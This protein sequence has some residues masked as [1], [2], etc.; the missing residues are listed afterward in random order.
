MKNWKIGIRVTAGFGA[1]VAIAMA[2]GIFAYSKVNGIENNAAEVVDGALPKVYLVG[3]IEKNV[4]RTLALA[5]QHSAADHQ[6][7]AGLEAQIQTIRSTNSGMVSQYEKLVNT[8][9]GRA[10]LQDFQA[11]RTAFWG[12]LDE[13]IQTSRTG[14]A[15]AKRR[16]SD[17]ISQRVEPLQEKYA[18]AAEAVVTLNKEAADEAGANPSW[19]PEAAPKRASRSVWRSL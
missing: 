15:D 7:M 10:L 4:H 19:I 3:Q 14:T 13:T 12:A 16:A 9:K 2:L 17:M 6:K 11:A 18:Q 5:L 1:V 8:D